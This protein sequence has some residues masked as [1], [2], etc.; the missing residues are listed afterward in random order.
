MLETPEFSKQFHL[1]QNYYL[2]QLDFLNWY[3]Y[4]FI[5]KEVTDL[6][7]KD[8]L[9]IGTGSGFVKNC[10]QP[11][12][13]K[14]VVLDINPKLKP[15]LVGD[16]RAYQGGLENNFDCVI[17][18]D[19]LEHLPFDDVEQSLKHICSYLKEEGKL[20]VTIPHRRSHF[21]LMT[22]LQVDP[23]VFT[24]PSGFL[25]FG[26]F[27]R[28]FIKRKI[29]IDPDHCWEIGDGTVKNVNVDRLFKKSGFTIE[30]FKK[31]LYVDFWVLKKEAVVNEKLI[32]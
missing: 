20:L 9:E 19:V 23:W 3:R 30:R 31:L 18:A 8:V 22:P 26:A 15:D 25:S 4:F 6:M 11:L 13:R 7:P 27:Y 2:K 12:V 32:Y 17:I 1:E 21:L 14:Y 5:I 16:V 24:V 10:L 29:W 28:R